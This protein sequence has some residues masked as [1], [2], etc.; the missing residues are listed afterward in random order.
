MIFD[1]TTEYGGWSAIT[2]TFLILLLTSFFLP[3]ILPGNQL[4]HIPLVGDEEGSVEKRRQKFGLS[5]KKL[6]VEGYRKVSVVDHMYCE[7]LR[8]FA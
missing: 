2:S 5:A 6:Y 1:A 7:V 3:R 8:E 4:A